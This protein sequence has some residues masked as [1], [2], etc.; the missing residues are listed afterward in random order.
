[1]AVSVQPSLRM[2]KVGYSPIRKAFQRANELR[3]QGRSIIDLT[4]G[5]PDFDSPGAAKTAALE[6]IE[7]GEVHY[8]ANAGIIELRRALAEKLATQNGLRYDPEQEIIV[9]IGATEA[10]YMAMA[11]FLDPGDEVLI[12]SPGYLSYYHCA[13]LVDACPKPVPMT[14][15]DKGFRPDLAAFAAAITPR[16]KL[17]LVNSP[18]NPTGTVWTREELLRLADLADRHNLLILSD[19]VYEDIIFDGA[20]RVSIGALPGAAGRTL[21]VF[22]LSKTYSMTGWR[23]GYLAGPKDLI[24]V[25]MRVHQHVGVCAPSISQW[26]ALGA[27]RHGQTFI[28]R[29]AS[30]YARRREILLDGFAS[31]GIP[32]PC[33]QGTFYS[34][35]SVAH[36]GMTSSEGVRFM[37]EDCGVATVPGD[38]FGPGGEGRVRISFASAQDE[39]AEA[40]R[41]L[42][43]GFGRR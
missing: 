10:L 33:P 19:E 40:V 15:T 41:R 34:L 24:A 29:C 38:A 23:V 25:A 4:L 43:D 35:P 22:S 8:T 39:I 9:T 11:A 5:R 7:Q 17:V 37:L 42:R 31:M 32:C 1:M 16:T 28:D 13:S 21:T 3:A 20:E 2:S 14:A 27:I 6:A 36:L 12:P 18:Q 30:E 26:A